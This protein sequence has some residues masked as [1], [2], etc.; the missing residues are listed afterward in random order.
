[1]KKHLYPIILIAISVISWLANFPSLPEDIPVHW[2]NG[3]VDGYQSKGMAF[4]TLHAIMIFIYILMMVL[5]KIDPKKKNYTYFSKGYMRINYALITLFFVIN[6]IILLISLGNDIP[7]ERLAGPFVGVLF[8]ILGNYLQQ[9]RTN[10]F[11]G[12]RTPWTLSNEEVWMKTHRL[13]GKLFMGGGLLILLTFF[14]PTEWEFYIITGV[15]AII[16]V[17]PYAYSYFLFKSITKES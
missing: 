13:G 14:M 6:M 15:V 10:F 17:V 7:M 9:A 1:M 3:G 16:V 4:I 11:I 5:P 12:L 8:M 2:G